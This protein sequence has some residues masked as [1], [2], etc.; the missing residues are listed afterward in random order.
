MNGNN[1]DVATALVALVGIVIGA[2]LQYIFSRSTESL[3]QHQTLKAQSY[4][5]FVKSLA[6]ITIA[7]RHHNKGR[8]LE[9]TILLADSK[10][11]VAIYGS[12]SVIE[13]IANFFS[14]YGE[15]TSPESIT[16]F[17]EIIQK[18]RSETLKKQEMVIDNYISILLVGPSDNR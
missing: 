6:G 13:S 18:M 3:K 15:I 14:R 9:S 4:V 10:A 5:D 11:R 16:S 1:F 7:Q 8:E 17:I 2:I 12:K